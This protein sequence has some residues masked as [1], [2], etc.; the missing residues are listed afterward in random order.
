VSRATYPWRQ[1]VV[2]VSTR[3]PAITPTAA[4]TVRIGPVTLLLVERPRCHLWVVPRRLTPDVYLPCV[5]RLVLLDVLDV[6]RGKSSLIAPNRTRA[7]GVL[8]QN[9]RQHPA[10][11]RG[12][13]NRSTG[14]TVLLDHAPR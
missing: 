8:P 2:F 7:A 14:T 11:R 1:N 5:A 13:E 12:R 3:V 4:T 10:A 6:L 9:V